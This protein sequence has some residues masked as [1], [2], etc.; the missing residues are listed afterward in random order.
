MCPLRFVVSDDARGDRLYSIF[1]S[2]FDRQPAA[3]ADV[4]HYVSR[5]RKQFY[6]A[7]GRRRALQVTR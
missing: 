3:M 1:I 6:L 7:I 5:R 4:I 2:V